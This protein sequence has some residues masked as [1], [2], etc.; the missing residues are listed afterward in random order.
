VE[1]TAHVNMI[2]SHTAVNVTYRWTRKGLFC[3]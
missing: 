1:I 3:M 2:A